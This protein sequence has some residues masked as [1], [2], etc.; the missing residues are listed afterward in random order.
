MVKTEPSKWNRYGIIHVHSPRD[1]YLNELLD[2]LDLSYST[3]GNLNSEFRVYTLYD[4]W[5]L[6]RI[7]NVWF[8]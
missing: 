1:R 5:T 2:K 6:N 7:N 4:L 8:V 3:L